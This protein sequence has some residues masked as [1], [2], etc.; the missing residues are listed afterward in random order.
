MGTKLVTV[1]TF[2]SYIEAEMAKQTLRDNGIEAFATGENASNV[3]PIPAV[4]GP[5][6]KV[7]EPDAERAREILESQRAE[8]SEEGQE[9][10]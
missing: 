7:A 10:Q 8:P 9:E 1:A 4:E 3:Y 6:L 5:E 2:N